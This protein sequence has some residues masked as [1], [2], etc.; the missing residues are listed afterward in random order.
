[1]E[2]EIWRIVD[3]SYSLKIGTDGLEHSYGINLIDRDFTLLAENCDLPA[4][5]ESWCIGER[6]NCIMRNVEDGT[7]VF[8][9]KRFLHKVEPR[10]Q[11]C[12]KTL[13]E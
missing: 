7:I 13:D 11:C 1:M 2:K 4:D 12:G 3:G 6:N 9:Q 5:T 10:Y 8:I